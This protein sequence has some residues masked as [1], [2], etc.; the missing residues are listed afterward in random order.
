MRRLVKFNSSLPLASIEERMERNELNQAGDQAEFMALG[1]PNPDLTCDHTF[2]DKASVTFRQLNLNPHVKEI[3]SVP[4]SP[5]GHTFIY[6]SPQNDKL[7][8]MNGYY[9]TPLKVPDG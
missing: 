4:I 7:L 8:G 1:K 3:Q 6:F 9:A 5:D 2:T